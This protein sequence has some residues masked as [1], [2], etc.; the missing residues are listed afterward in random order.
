MVRHRSIRLLATRPGSKRATRQAQKA[1]Q[2]VVGLGGVAVV[3]VMTANG[4]WM[5]FATGLLS[6][7]LP[8]P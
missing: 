2:A 7:L 4:S 1:A 6:L 3:L 5:P 8:V